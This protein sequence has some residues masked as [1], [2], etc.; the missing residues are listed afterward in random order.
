MWCALS[1]WSSF[2]YG[3]FSSS[4]FA[5]YQVIVGSLPHNLS[6]TLHLVCVSKCKLRVPVYLWCSY[7][8]EIRRWEIGS[9]EC[10]VLSVSLQCELTIELWILCNFAET[11]KVS[12]DFW[13]ITHFHHFS[14][15]GESY[16]RGTRQ[17][18]CR[19]SFLCHHLDAT[20]GEE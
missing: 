19:V 3:S 12:W 1:K 13:L 2:T 10:D 8:D 11:S 9:L 5:R 16:N 14:W 20:L 15:N 6:M 7:D 4:S 18:T 17:R